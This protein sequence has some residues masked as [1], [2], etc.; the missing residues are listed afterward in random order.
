MTTRRR[1]VRRSSRHEHHPGTDPRMPEYPTHDPEQAVDGSEQKVFG[2][3]VDRER[4]DE[5]PDPD[6]E[7]A[8][9]GAANP[10]TTTES[11]A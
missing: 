5:S 9:S 6:Q 8:A 7:R 10:P 1:I 3:T 4:E 2:S 11:P